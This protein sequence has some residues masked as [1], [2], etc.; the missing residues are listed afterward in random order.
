MIL[1]DVG[2][3]QSFFIPCELISY[4]ESILPKTNSYISNICSSSGSDVSSLSSNEVA[5]DGIE[6]SDLNTVGCRDLYN[7]EELRDKMERDQESL[8]VIL[9][10]SPKRLTMSWCFPSPSSLRTTNAANWRTTGCVI[11]SGHASAFAGWRGGWK[12]TTNCQSPDG[13][14]MIACS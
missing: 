7:V 1:D 4:N 8:P 14:A 6:S 9:P 2:Y 3:F 5:G 12:M 13:W 11:W 10:P